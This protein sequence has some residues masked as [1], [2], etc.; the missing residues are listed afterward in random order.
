MNRVVLFCGITSCE[1]EDNLR[2]A[3]MRGQEFGDI[4]Y[5]PVQYN[6]AVVGTVV[7]RN[8]QLCQLKTQQTEN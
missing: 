5:I 6:P 3:G 4:P 8:Y 2:V 1:L 7:L